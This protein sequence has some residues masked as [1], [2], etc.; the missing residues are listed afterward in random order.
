MGCI[1]KK[2]R[3]AQCAVLLNFKLL[4]GSR[5]LMSS[6]SDNHSQKRSLEASEDEGPQK[7]RS[8]LSLSATITEAFTDELA[9]YVVLAIHREY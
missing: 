2:T 4:N 9:S 7:K 6:N 1:L 3:L 5:P 8:C